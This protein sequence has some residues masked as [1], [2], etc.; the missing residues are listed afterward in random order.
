VNVYIYP[1]DRD[2][3]RFLS[4][5]PGI[6]EVNFWRPGGKQAFRQ[7]EPG[8][9]FL[10]RLGQPDNAI[11]GGGIYTHFS[12]AP[13]VQVWEAFERKNGTPDYAT[14]QRLI[15]RYKKLDDAP[16]QV[17]STIIGCIVL[18]APF[19]LHRNRWIPI[20]SEYEVN[21]PQGQRFDD[22]S[23]VGRALIAEIDEAL[24]V[25][26]LAH[27]AEFTP[28][29]V[30]FGESV[31]KRRL[32]QGGF[33]LVVADAYEKRCAVSGE[34]TYPVLEAAHIVP[35]SQGG[36]HTPQN[37]LLLR[38]DIHKLFDRGYVTIRPNGE[39]A[40]STRLRDDWQNGRIY[41]DLDQRPIRLP[42]SEALRPDRKA[43]EWHNDAV[44]K[45]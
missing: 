21:S 4:N 36:H 12:F 37:G 16:E 33:S 40:V 24:R 45:R 31:V 27:V 42:N 30:R 17:A 8:D 6:D 18:T 38:S 15:A 19:F 39:F 23:A 13:I 41:Y 44:F 1:T 26:G 29:E 2:W 22:S 32:G 28:G 10:F 7:L 43:L 35:V 25:P 14:F 3:Y 9:L 5:E 20:P 34:R 11:A